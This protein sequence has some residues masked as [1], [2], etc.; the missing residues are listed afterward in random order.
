MRS[1]AING[2][3][4]RKY[5]AALLAIMLFLF[6]CSAAAEEEAVIPTDLTD[7]ETIVETVENEDA[8]FD[9]DIILKASDVNGTGNTGMRRQR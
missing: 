1:S 4:L 8:V 2:T 6:T 5:A 3:A 7:P 9:S